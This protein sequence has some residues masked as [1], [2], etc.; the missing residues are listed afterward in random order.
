MPARSGPAGPRGRVSRAVRRGRTVAAILIAG[1]AA[2]GPLA[3]APQAL[4]ASSQA[5]RGQL[6]VVIESVSPQWARPGHTVTVSGIVHNGTRVTQDGLSV[7][8]RSSASPLTSEDD[9]S[10]Y[11]AGRYAADAPE[12]VPVTLAGP[13][14]P[15]GTLHWRATLNPDAAGMSTSGFGVYPLAAQI[16]DSIGL[17]AATD[18]TFL[19]FWPGKSGL[20]PKRLNVG[21]LWP[22]LAQPE[23]AI[24]RALLSN[25]LAASVAG[26]G[27]LTRLLDAGRSYSAAAQLTWAIDPALVR[28]AQ[29]MSHPYAVQ[30]KDGCTNA[31]A[32]PADS[33]ARDWLTGLQGAISGQQAFLTPYADVDVAAL[34]H[35]GLDADLRSAFTEGRAVGSKILHLPA[36]ADTMA[37]P[38]GGLADAGVLGSLAANRISTFVLDSTVMPPEGPPPDYTPSAQTSTASAG[39][40]SSLNVLLA[41]HTISQILAT[42]AT[43]PGSAFATEQRFLAQTA[44]IT[45][46]LP[47]TTRSLVVAPPRLWNPAPGLASG[48]LSE[49]VHAPWLRP[50]SLSSMAAQAHPSGR[51]PRRPPPPHHVSRSELSRGYLGHVASLG[52]SIRLQASIFT[53]RQPGYLNAAVAALESVDWPGSRAQAAA[54]RRKLLDEVQDYVDSQGKKVGIIDSGQHFTLSGASGKVPVSIFNGLH[55]AVRVKLRAQAPTDRLRIGT[56]DTT[57]TVAAGGTATVRLPVHAATVGATEMTLSLLSPSGVVL[58]GTTVQLP[59]NASQF[60]T[61]ALVVLFV[62]LG[63]FILASFA[64][65]VRRS[66]RE[67]GQHGPDVSGPPGAAAVAGSVSSGEDLENDDPPEDPDEYA[68]ARGRARR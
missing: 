63:L 26:D 48:L 46:E 67:N 31:K 65:A 38:S 5:A 64:R 33:A 66:R 58:P 32:M 60:G 17:P 35:D 11:A 7:Q 23:Q 68:D 49:T 42:P 62:A 30:T 6:S 29:T 8:L 43:G 22:M 21:W 24:C 41:N 25:G 14:R 39:V 55:T 1:A 2:A 10:L 18:R 4:A 3:V 28:T 44:M 36:S 20:K 12:G 47:N 59:V 15:G 37:W 34:S 19:P 16:L 53:P 56:V 52:T 57:V 50:T 40:G 13:I 51:V 54:A 45:A 27:R 9:L 61:L